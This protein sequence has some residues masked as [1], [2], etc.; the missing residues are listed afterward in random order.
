MIHPIMK[1]TVITRFETLRVR[2]EWFWVPHP[3]LVM[4]SVED[5]ADGDL[6]WSEVGI[7]SVDFK[8]VSRRTR[9][10]TF[11]VT[12]MSSILNLLWR[13]R[14]LLKSLGLPPRKRNACVFGDNQKWY[15][16]LNEGGVYL[17]AWVVDE[18]KDN[19]DFCNCTISESQ[20]F[21]MVYIDTQWSLLLPTT[22]CLGVEIDS[23]MYSSLYAPVFSAY[24]QIL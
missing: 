3:R 4:D 13:S 7:T 17:P 21:R 5:A 12:I 2:R 19:E 6:E 9:L 18:D 16:S 24:L 15:L 22:A 20:S 1:C 14:C 10:R 23:Q 11:L 8:G